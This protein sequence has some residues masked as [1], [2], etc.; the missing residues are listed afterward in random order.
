M[1]VERLRYL[2]SWQGLRWERR[3]AA[4]RD[5]MKVAALHQCVARWQGHLH[6]IGRH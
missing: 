3:N 2:E 5:E 6:R 4:R 1:I